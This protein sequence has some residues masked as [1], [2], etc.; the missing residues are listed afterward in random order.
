[1]SSLDLR[2]CVEVTCV[3]HWGWETPGLCRPF[4]VKTG[5][6]PRHA[7]YRWFAQVKGLGTRE[8]LPERDGSGASWRL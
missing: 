3:I 7:P 8:P 5:P 6:R 4:L 2:L 1:M